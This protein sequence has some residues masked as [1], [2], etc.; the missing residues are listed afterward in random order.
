LCRVAQQQAWQ[1]CIQVQHTVRIIQ[2]QLVQRD[3]RLP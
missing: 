1:G 2:Q 3:P